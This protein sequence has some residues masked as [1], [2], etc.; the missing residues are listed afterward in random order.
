[1]SEIMSLCDSVLADRAA[2][3]ALADEDSMRALNAAEPIARRGRAAILKIIATSAGTL[4]ECKA[5]ARL[6][7]AIP[8]D[9]LADSLASDLIALAG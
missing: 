2:L 5:K 9:D 4:A 6:L 8:R 7:K 1:M 3:L